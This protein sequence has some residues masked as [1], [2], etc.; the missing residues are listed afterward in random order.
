[1]EVVNNVINL[2]ELLSTSL[3]IN[4]YAHVHFY[5]YYGA[6]CVV[7]LSLYEVQ[8]YV[9]ASLCSLVQFDGAA[10]DSTNSL[11]KRKREQEREKTHERERKRERQRDRDRERETERERERERERR[12]RERDRERERERERNLDRPHKSE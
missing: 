1:M 7:Y 3:Y 11:H 8:Q 5:V 2:Y 12:E 9:D 4:P 6:V 10:T